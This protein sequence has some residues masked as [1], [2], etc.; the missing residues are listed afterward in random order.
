MSL[1]VRSGSVALGAAVTILGTGFSALIIPL[2]FA[3]LTTA[4]R[5]I[6]FD[7]IL[8]VLLYL[9]AWSL[10]NACFAITRAGGDTATGFIA[11]VSVN[12]F[13]F[14]PL[15]F[16]LARCTAVPPVGMLAIAKL[17]DIVK[18]GICMYF[19]RKERWVRNLT[20]T[21]GRPLSG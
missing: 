21:R 13:L 8:V 1:W 5:T 9:P 7:L 19:F 17:S 16:I 3:R 4:A 11:D 15:I 12:T 2:A 10:L 6:A 14:L 20:V 18:I